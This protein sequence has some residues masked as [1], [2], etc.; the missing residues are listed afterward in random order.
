MW[1]QIICLNLSQVQK[2]LNSRLRVRERKRKK[3][4]W[5]WFYFVYSVFNSTAGQGNFSFFLLH[6]WWIKILRD[7]HVRAISQSL[8]LFGFQLLISNLFLNFF[9]FCLSFSCMSA[10]Y[11]LAISFEKFEYFFC[12]EKL[13]AKNLIFRIA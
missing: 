1:V 12:F 8:Y 9:S 7:I 3:E 10:P 4:S 5:L 6:F 2:I 11:D 13:R